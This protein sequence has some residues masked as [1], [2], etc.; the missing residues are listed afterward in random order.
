MSDRD[1]DVTG[2]AEGYR[3]A[4]I[5]CPGCAASMR[6]LELEAPDAEVD[7]C[8]RCGGLWVDW[9]DGE[10]RVI[11]AG[12]LRARQS[13]PAAE[14]PVSSRN[15]AEAAGACPRCH[16]QLVPEHYEIQAEIPSRRDLE[17]T[18]LV[19]GRT[20]AELLRCEDCMG[21]FVAHSSAEILA[22][23]TET[24]EPP[25]SHAAKELRPLPWASFVAVVKSFLGR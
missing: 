24:D 25:P 21:S 16:K 11:A 9:F 17:K 20:G 7:V 6:L 15:E 18:S 8:D 23:L 19:P 4:G 10:V 22:W 1:R 2:R 3:D 13:R 12:A 14:S 5:R